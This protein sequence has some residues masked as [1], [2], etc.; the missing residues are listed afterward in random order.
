MM[1]TAAMTTMT[2]KMIAIAIALYVVDAK[3]ILS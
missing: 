1:M 2:T 3:T